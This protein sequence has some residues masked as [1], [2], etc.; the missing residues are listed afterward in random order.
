MSRISAP[1]RASAS[2][3]AAIAAGVV[4]TLLFIPALRNGFVYDDHR[5]YSDNA[6]LIHPSIFWRAFLDPVCQTSDLTHA[7]LWR[8]LRTLSFALDRFLAG[9]DPF[10]PHL[11][12]L[13]LHGLGA[14][15]VARLLT[16]WRAP[17]IAAFLGAIAYACH[18]VQTECV[19]WISSRGDLLAAGFAHRQAAGTHGNAV[20][21]DRAGAALCNAASVFG[22]GEA[23]ILPDCP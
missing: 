2:G 9:G 11:T 10:G 1:P 13:V 17:P 23:D 12:N 15:L 5:F 7:G 6:Y 19:A 4:A 21:M 22:A 20:D 8:P 14:M 18:P 3:W 16:M